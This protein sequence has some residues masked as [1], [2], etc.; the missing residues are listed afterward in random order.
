MLLPHTPS[1]RRPLALRVGGDAEAAGRPRHVRRRA[2]PPEIAR[3]HTRSHEI[4][5]NR[6]CVGG[7]T[8]LKR[9]TDGRMD[10][11]TCGRVDG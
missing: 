6:S 8:H 3:D 10:G 9:W 4:T 2:D 1:A 11:W 5:R 7:Q